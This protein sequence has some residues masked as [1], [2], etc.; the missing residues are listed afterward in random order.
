MACAALPNT[1]GLRLTLTQ[2]GSSVEGTAEVGTFQLPV[3][4]PVTSG[5]LVLTGQGRLLAFTLNIFDWSSTI[6]GTA[7]TGAFSFRLVPDDPSGGTATM[8]AVLQD[9]VKTS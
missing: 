3:S 7:M 8:R 6:S 9:V 2:T 5:A 1:G 4:G